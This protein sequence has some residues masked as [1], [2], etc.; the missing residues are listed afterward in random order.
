MTLKKMLLVGVLWQCAALSASAHAAHVP[1]ATSSATILMFSEQEQGNTVHPVRMVLTHRYL[2]IDD[3]SNKNGF[4][5]LDRKRRTVYNVSR[6]DKTILVIKPRRISLQRPAHFGESV[7]TD[8]QAFPSIAGR[9]VVHYTL[10]VGKQRCFDVYAAAG[11]L[12]DAVAA[13]RDYYEIPAGEQAASE[14]KTPP[15]MR[16][17][18]DLANYIFL[19]AHFLD[20]GFPVRQVDGN[21]T[22][23]QLVDFKTGVSVD[24]ELFELP[25]NY[26]R[27]SIEDMADG[28]MH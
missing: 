11:L 2:R 1:P 28:L 19:P 12:P 22:L 10:R 24:A 21:G 13:L 3:G 9:K 16:S 26:R 4:V 7:V 5:L 23:R 14:E 15:S 20:F 25:A 8:R 17:A 6:M 18:C 27:Y